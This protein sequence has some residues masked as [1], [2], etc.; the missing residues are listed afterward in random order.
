MLNVN[1][2]KDTI[3]IKVSE[4]EKYENILKE[5]KKVTRAKKILQWRRNANTS[6]RENT[7][8]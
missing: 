1:A 7:K 5:L 2:K 4:E 8:K 6:N 3:I